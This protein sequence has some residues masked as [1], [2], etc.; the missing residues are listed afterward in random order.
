MAITAR[1][2]VFDAASSGNG[3]RLPVIDAM[4]TPVLEAMREAVTRSDG[5]SKA[6][7]SKSKPTAAFPTLAGADAIANDLLIQFI[8]AVNASG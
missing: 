4:R 7:P 1:E 6:C 3:W 5:E 8:P 2:A